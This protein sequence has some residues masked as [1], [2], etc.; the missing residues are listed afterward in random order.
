MPSSSKILHTINNSTHIDDLKSFY[1]EMDDEYKRVGNHYGFECNGCKDNCCY[2][3]F[4]HHTLIEFIY[5]MEGLESLDVEMQNAIITKAD[6]ACGKINEADLQN[7]PVR[8]MCPLNFDNKCI[9]YTYRP[10]IC[11]LH[12][13][14]HELKKPGQKPV[15]S[16]GCDLFTEQSEKKKYCSFDR[17][18]FYMEMA[19]LEKALRQT[20]KNTEKFKMTIARMIL[21]WNNK[22]EIP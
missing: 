22:I 4:Y 11:R 3:R 14:S 6:S 1:S 5:L 17:T 7:S 19:R 20:L 18:P 16:P 15:F 8:V 10:M 2:T 13:L 9:L 21:S 12:G